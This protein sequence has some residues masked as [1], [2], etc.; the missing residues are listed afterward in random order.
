MPVVKQQSPI[1]ANHHKFVPA[2]RILNGVIAICGMRN[3]FIRDAI[4]PTF[5]GRHIMQLNKLEKCSD[6]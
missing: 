5:A 4:Q 6:T 3:Q 2:K 1:I